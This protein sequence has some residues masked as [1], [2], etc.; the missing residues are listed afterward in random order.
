MSQPAERRDF[1]RVERTPSSKPRPGRSAPTQ[2]ARTPE[3]R[4][5]P[6][7]ETVLLNASVGVQRVMGRLRRPQEARR[8]SART[9]Q[10][11]S[12]A[13]AR[14]MQ[15]GIHTVVVASRLVPVRETTLVAE[16]PPTDS[17]RPLLWRLCHDRAVAAAVAGILVVGSV[18][19]ISG[20]HTVA[21]TGNTIG[22]GSE[23]RLAVGGVDGGG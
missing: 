6:T 4:D 19:S 1:G 10:I 12:L 23:P 5:R 13:A 2:P 3:R 9:L 16:R 8:P 11:R 20:G 17:R 21:A 15:R 7:Q 18:V 14:H 22:A